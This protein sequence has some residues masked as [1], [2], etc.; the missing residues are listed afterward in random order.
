MKDKY[1]NW[2]SENVK[3]HYGKCAETTL[4]MQSIF[5]ELKRIRGHYYCP[6]WG[7]RTHWWL[8]DEEEVVDP[9]KDQFPS[10]GLGVYVP[11]IEGSPEPTGKCPNCGELVY[12]GLLLCSQ[13]CHREY[14]E[15]CTNFRF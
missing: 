13:S 1:S 2:I 8:L 14:V 7:E 10:K 6:F 5:P 3:E 9:T 15:Y 12:N 11:W 4:E